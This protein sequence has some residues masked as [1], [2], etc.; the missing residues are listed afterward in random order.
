MLY[1]YSFIS[2]PKIYLHVTGDGD[3]L[4]G[5]LRQG[6]GRIKIEAYKDKEGQ[7][8]LTFG[9]AHLERSIALLSTHVEVVHLI[10][11]YN[12]RQHCT[13][14]C[15]RAYRSSCEC[16]CLGASHGRSDG[17]WSNPVGELQ[18]QDERT[19]AHYEFTAHTD[20]L[21]VADNQ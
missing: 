4:L 1:I 7:W 17:F 15:Q 2:D 13:S 21:D 20:E 16:S 8:W 19:I 11:E 3:Q 10:K 5:R 18:F 6:L 9:K 14:S 12:T